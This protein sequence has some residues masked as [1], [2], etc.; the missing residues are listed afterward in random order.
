MAKQFPIYTNPN[1]FEPAGPFDIPSPIIV[2]DGVALWKGTNSEN[3]VM[4]ALHGVECCCG[5]ATIPCHRCCTGSFNDNNACCF[6]YGIDATE[7][8]KTGLDLVQLHWF[9]QIQFEQGGDISS[10]DITLTSQSVAQRLGV[11]CDG[12]GGGQ[13]FVF[14]AEVTAIRNG[15]PPDTF[16]DE[17][18]LV[19]TSPRASCLL[20]SDYWFNTIDAFGAVIAQDCKPTDT[21]LADVSRETH[22]L[23][24]KDCCLHWDESFTATGVDSRGDLW[25]R[26][27][28]FSYTI[29]N[30]TEP[31]NTEC[32][33][34]A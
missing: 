11:P 20:T 33:G 27:F 28:S 17:V 23:N 22:G 32:N 19:H 25:Q 16:E 18:T 12:A 8:F 2:R 9:D 15:G 34:C 7:E 13:A 5:D 26:V 10:R 3:P 1:R 29:E 14:T 21:S 6:S 24:C 4:V 31:C 30:N